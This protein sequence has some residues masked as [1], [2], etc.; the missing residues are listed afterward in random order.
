MEMTIVKRS[1]QSGLVLLICVVAIAGCSEYSAKRE[2]SGKG[3]ELKNDSML[4]AID[5]GDIESVRLFLTAKLELNPQ[6]GQTPLHRAV[7]KRQNSIVDLLVASGASANNPGSNGDS[8]PLDIAIFY[9]DEALVLKLISAGANINKKSDVERTTPLA[10][11][12]LHAT[13]TS[14]KC[15]KIVKFLEDKGARCE[16]P[17]EIDFKTGVLRPSKICE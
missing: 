6:Y 2:L 7:A 4:R 3:Y 17:P 9:C 8:E 5:K 11:A 16:A 14:Y 15:F 12:K 1:L 13:I 10:K